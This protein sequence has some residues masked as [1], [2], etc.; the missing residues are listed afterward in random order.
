MLILVLGLT[1]GSGNSARIGLVDADGG[2]MA[3]QLVADLESSPGQRVEIRRYDSVDA[4]R[5]A[6]SRGIVQVGLAIPAGYSSAIASGAQ[7]RVTVVAAP[8]GM[9]SAV[10]S[11]VDQAI[12]AQAMTLRAARFSAATAGVP[13]ASALA[14]AR[15]LA[16]GVPGV[17]VT[18]EPINAA[19]SVNGYD[20][21]AQSQLVLFMF[22]TSLTGAVELVLTRQLGI[23]RRLFSTPTGL[24]TIISGESAARIAF[25]VAQGVFIVAAS[26]ILFG[27]QWGDPVA[28]GAVV[29]VFSLVSGGAAMV[30][31]S[32]A[33]NPSQA[34]ALG[35]ALGMLF[36]LLGGAMVPAELF[37]EAMRTLSRLTP[38]AWAVEALRSLGEPGTGVAAIAPQL[39]VLLG[40]AGVFFAVSVLRFRQVL[41]SGG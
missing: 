6:A 26:A 8:T 27:V 9:A 41:R 29:L 13:F 4:L 35:P 3:A 1:Y 17:A 31:G 33:S 24:W 16:A 20:A 32:L 10:G 38:H 21:G 19:V 36:G 28:V 37:P 2:P 14:A 18:V 30:V 11:T 7:A 25:A 23:S 12:T 40:F 5:D 22:L 15:S 39:A 34:G